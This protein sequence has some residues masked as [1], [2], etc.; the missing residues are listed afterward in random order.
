MN[1]LNSFFRNFFNFIKIWKNIF[2][3]FRHFYNVQ[4]YSNVII[5]N[6]CVPKV[7]SVSLYLLQLEILKEKTVEFH[8]FL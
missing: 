2:K 5:D 4:K 8:F 3:I 7:S 1:K 6:V